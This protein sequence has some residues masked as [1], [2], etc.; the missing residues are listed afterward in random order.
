MFGSLRARVRPA[1]IVA[2]CAVFLTF[3]TTSY[4]AFTVGAG[5]I[6]AGAVTTPKL[7]QHAVTAAKLAKG[8]VTARAIANGVITAQKLAPAAASRVGYADVIPGASPSF[9]PGTTS[10]F[11]S[12]SHAATGTYCLTP[13]AGIPA[14]SGVIVASPDTA[15]SSGLGSLLSVSVSTVPGAP[16][17]AAGSF[18]VTTAVLASA[19]GVLTKSDSIAFT[20]IAT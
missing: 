11:V 2:A 20:V 7:H 1:W 15:H 3:G 4:A 6:R 16:D 17:C 14:A 9:A 18:E 12:V 5:Q 13:A 19:V 10:R 8:A